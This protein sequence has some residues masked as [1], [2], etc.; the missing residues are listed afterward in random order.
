MFS[1][2][3]LRYSFSARFA[4][5]IDVHRDVGNVVVVE[6]VFSL[7]LSKLVSVHVE[8]CN[9]VS[10]AQ[11]QLQIP[12]VYSNHKHSPVEKNKFREELQIIQTRYMYAMNPP[13][14]SNTLVDWGARPRGAVQR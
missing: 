4:Y 14:V 5:L 12:I 2:N 11:L 3:F 8:A 13:R 7:V 6:F 1:L 9:L 10:C